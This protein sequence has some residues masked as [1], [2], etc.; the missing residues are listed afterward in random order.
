MAGGVLRLLGL[1][2]IWGPDMLLSISGETAGGGIILIVIP[3]GEIHTGGT[4]PG[5]IIIRITGGIRITHGNT[6]DGIIH[7]NMVI[8][9]VT[10][11]VTIMG[12]ITV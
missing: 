12:I 2:D 9:T 6:A 7:G 10:T 5:I 11:T 1:M 4:I 3:A 8:G